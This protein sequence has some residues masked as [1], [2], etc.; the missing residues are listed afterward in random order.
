MESTQAPFFTIAAAI[1]ILF[2]SARK[3]LT[4][5]PIGDIPHNDLSP[6]VGDLPSILG[7]INRG[8]GVA[9]WLSDQSARLGPIM[10]IHMTCFFSKVAIMDPE[11][12]EDI[13][14]WRADEFGFSDTQKVVFG[15]AIPN[16]MLSIPN[17]S[18]WNTHRRLLS[19]WYV[20][21]FRCSGFLTL[22]NSMSTQY[23]KRCVPRIHEVCRQLVG[24]WE[25][26]LE[27]HLMVYA[28]IH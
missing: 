24:I 9:T 19:A 2:Y 27:S 15:G 25:S 18:M 6:V 11:E 1:V 21:S 20:I 22:I 8:L 23:L 3:K 13:L 7:Y 10:S 12:V 28:L 5:K 17:N 16:E 4:P 26:K 14:T